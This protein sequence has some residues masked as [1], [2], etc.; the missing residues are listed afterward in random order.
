MGDKKLIKEIELE[1]KRNFDDNLKFV[2]FSAE[3]IKGKSNRVWS[4]RQKILIDEVYKSNRKP[5]K[6]P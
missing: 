3:W 1:K 6:R 4:K 5:V 2:I